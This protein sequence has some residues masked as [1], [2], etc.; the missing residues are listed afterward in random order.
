MDVFGNPLLSVGDII[1]IKY[2]YQGFAG[3]EKMIIT[4]VTNRYDS[5]LET[6][7]VCRTL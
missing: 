1:T 6:S 3:T 5:G 7:I 2:T 4:N